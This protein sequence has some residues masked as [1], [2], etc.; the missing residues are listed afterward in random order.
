M[1]E[2]NRNY[3]VSPANKK[4]VDIQELQILLCSG[5]VTAQRIGIE[6]ESVVRVGRRVLYN[7]SKIQKYLDTVSE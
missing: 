4:L 1:R 6:A 7:V 5:R 3:D 2:T